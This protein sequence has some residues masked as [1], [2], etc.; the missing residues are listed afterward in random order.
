LNAERLHVVAKAIQAELNST[1]TA[2]HIQ[3][4]TAHLQNLVNQ[5][6]N[7]SSQQQV[8]TKL[9]ELQGSLRSAPSNT[10]SPAWRQI[11]T[12]IGA[13]EFLGAPLADKIR[14]LIERNEKVTPQAAHQ[15][16]QPHAD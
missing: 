11:L 7:A 3:Q 16:L 8:A 6:G 12:E 9:A 1:R 13:D 2:E 14:D 4:L 15:G 10:F 5:P